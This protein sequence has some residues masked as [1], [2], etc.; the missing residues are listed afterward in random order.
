VI[1]R[2]YIT[3]QQLPKNEEPRISTQH[4]PRELLRASDFGQDA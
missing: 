3:R 1:T 2:S 4:R